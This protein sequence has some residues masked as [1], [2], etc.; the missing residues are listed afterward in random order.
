MVPISGSAGGGGPSNAGSSADSSGWTVNFGSGGVNAGP[1][2]ELSQ[3]LP[4]VLLAVGAL[5]AISYFKRRK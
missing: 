5:V 1:T 3:Y 4:F 2:S